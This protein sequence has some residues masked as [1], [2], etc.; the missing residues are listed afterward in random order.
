MAMTGHE[1]AIGLA[2]RA[3]AVCRH[4]LSNGC[5]SGRYWI[6]GDVRNTPGQSMF[7]RLAGP[8]TGKGAA[9]KWTDAATGEHGDLLDVIRESRGLVEFR[10]VAEEARRFL[11]LP[12]KRI[13]ATPYIKSDPAPIGSPEASRRLFAMSQPIPGTLAETYLHQR[14]I[15]S[16]QGTGALRFHPHCY[17]VP[18]D[19]GPTRTLP[20]MIASVTDLNGRQTGAHRT[21]L[22]MDGMNKA[23]VDTPR[24]AMGD[25]LGH[26]VR[27]GTTANVMAAG[28][29]IETVLT[30]RCVM[31][32]M[33]M[34]AALSASHLAA[35]LFPPALRHLYILRDNDPAGGQACD[36]LTD[37]AHQAGIEVIVLSPMMTAFTDDLCHLGLIALRAMIADQLKR[38]DRIR[39]LNRAA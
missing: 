31:P 30:L 38:C 23:P 22:A 35:I 7:V 11:S 32:T 17:Y 12:T 10:D 34:M 1:L 16:L 27:F 5:R 29:G 6:V 26:S 14:S 28:E 24:R 15:A 36:C 39:Y 20:A 18:E 9:G 37:R 3:E 4:Y 8:Q 21:W 33:P 19:G 2:A 25:L 13:D